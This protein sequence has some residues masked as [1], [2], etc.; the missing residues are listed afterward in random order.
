[1]ANCVAFN[2]R[3][4]LRSTTMCVPLGRLGESL[5]D[6]NNYIGSIDKFIGKYGNSE[7]VGKDDANAG[8]IIVNTGKKIIDMSFSQNLGIDKIKINSIVME[9]KNKKFDVKTHFPSTPF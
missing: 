2:I 8:I 6:L 9:L 5:D 3:H 4:S 1:M 7:D